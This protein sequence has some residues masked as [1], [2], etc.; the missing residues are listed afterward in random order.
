MSTCSALLLRPAKLWRGWCR[1]GSGVVLNMSSVQRGHRWTGYSAYAASKA[2]L[3]MLTK[4]LAQE[5]SPHGVRVLALAPGAIQT[6]INQSVWSDP[7]M[8][9]GPAGED[10][11]GP[12]GNRSRRCRYGR[13]A[14]IGRGGLRHRRDGI[15]RWRHDRLSRLRAWRLRW[16]RQDVPASHPTWSS[17]AKDLV[18]TAI[19][20]GRLWATLGYGVVNEV[21]WPSTGEPQT[22]D[23]GFIVAGERDWFEVK[24]VNRYTP[25]GACALHS[26]TNCSP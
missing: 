14:R 23:L 9:A 2:G 10:F 15:C 3:S 21:Y 25:Y 8:L 22:R 24:R 17:S 13:G 12:Y 19:G 1:K 5:A 11:V 6:P 4:T 26:A 18:T 7:A 20:S 16:T